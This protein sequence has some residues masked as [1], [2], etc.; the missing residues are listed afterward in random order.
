MTGNVINLNDTK[1]VQEEIARMSV[2]RAEKEIQAVLEKY[3][4]ALM[5]QEIYQNGQ[6]VQVAFKCV[7]IQGQEVALT[8][9]NLGG[10]QNNR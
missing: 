2:E 6:L 7:F 3:T 10:D 5:C 1:A 9:E 4:C 8:Q